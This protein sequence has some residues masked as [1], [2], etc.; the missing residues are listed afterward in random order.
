MEKY[1]LKFLIITL[2]ISLYICKNILEIRSLKDFLKSAKNFEEVDTLLI[3][4]KMV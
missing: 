3:K 4:G 2:I 1:F